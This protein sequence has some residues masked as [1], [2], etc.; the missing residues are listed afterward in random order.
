MVSQPN[1][2]F[3][4]GRKQSDLSFSMVGLGLLGVVVLLILI[5]AVPEKETFEI[6]NNLNPD[7]RQ[8]LDV[9]K[10]LS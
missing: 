9:P 8:C 3:L 10:G 4:G 6:E 7:P 5:A 1:Y 2:C